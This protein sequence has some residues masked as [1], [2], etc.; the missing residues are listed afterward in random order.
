VQIVL[1]LS[2]LTSWGPLAQTSL[3]GGVITIQASPETNAATGFDFFTFEKLAD[4]RGRFVAYNNWSL[5]SAILYNSI[6]KEG[7]VLVFYSGT[8]DFMWEV[9]RVYPDWT[10][11]ANREN[12]DT[13]MHSS[14]GVAT[15]IMNAE[16]IANDVL[17][18]RH[19]KIWILS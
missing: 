14:E 19:T 6:Q 4:G 8:E 5:E 12:I 16:L 13:L 7:D 1:V 11:E 10:L 9:A 3:A 17:Y 2:I 18:D 15:V